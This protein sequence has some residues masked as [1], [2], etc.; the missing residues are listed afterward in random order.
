MKIRVQVTIS[1]HPFEQ[2][3]IIGLIRK[4]L[5]YYQFLKG[6]CLERNEEISL[7]F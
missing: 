3:F 7:K 1:K 2:D 5:P 6:M 4:W